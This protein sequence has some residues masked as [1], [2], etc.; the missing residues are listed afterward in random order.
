MKKLSSSFLIL[1]IL[2]AGIFISCKKESSLNGNQPPSSVERGRPP[3]KGKP[4]P[5]VAN[6][7]P[8]QTIIL[9]TNTV[10]L[11]G[12]ASTDPNN[13]I[14]TY[15]WTKI[16]GPSSFAISNANAVQT[17]VTNLIE[18]VYQFEL[19]VTD[20]RGLINK[21]MVQITALPTGGANSCGDSRPTVN[22]NLVTLGTLSQARVGMG[23]GAGA[24]KI[25]FAGGSTDGYYI[26]SSRVDFF[27]ISTQS[28]STAELSEPRAGVCVAAVGNKIFF[29]GGYYVE[30]MPPYDPETMPVYVMDVYDV[31]TNAWSVVD[32]P[33]GT[34]YNQSAVVDNKIFFSDGSNINIYDVNT[35][36]W[37]A[38]QLSDGRSDFSMVAANNKVYFAG[39]SDLQG[40]P[41]NRID[42]Y[43][44]ATNTWSVL[45]LAQAKVYTTG[46]A[47]ADKVYFAGGYNSYTTPPSTSCSVDIIDANTGA[48]SVQYLSRPSIGRMATMNNKIAFIP[49]EQLELDIYNIATNTWSIG[50]LPAA[51]SDLIYQSTIFSSNNTIY[52]TGSGISNIVYKLEF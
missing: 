27:D 8:D 46:I 4:S 49:Y 19:K 45:S 37:S 18:G 21:D 17:Q 12:S 48:Q 39:G 14:T 36:S 9:T 41:L 20:A 51:Q 7:G 44:N 23:V 31:T 25:V 28:W 50:I 42:I 34:T 10:T 6:A 1:S 38:A 22:A 16:S 24:G 52:V 26:T 30:Y 3:G 40:N 32:L 35:Q 15:L 13:D 43:D 33:Y 5:P 2:L 11:N 47:A 29:A